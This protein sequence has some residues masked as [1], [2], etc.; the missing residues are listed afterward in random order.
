[1]LND[2]K[3]SSAGLEEQERARGAQAWQASEE[4]LKVGQGS[5]EAGHSTPLAGKL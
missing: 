4:W 3:V 1:M 2:L 5:D